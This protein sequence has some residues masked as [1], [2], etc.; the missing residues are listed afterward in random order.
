MPRSVTAC[1]AAAITRASCFQPKPGV[2]CR[3]GDAHDG[4][5]SE[6]GQGRPN[7]GLPYNRHVH[8]LVVT[9]GF[10]L[11]GEVA[12][13]GAKNAILKH[14][15]ATL[16]AP[17]ELS[18]R[19]RPR[20][21]RCHLDGQRDRAHWRHVPLLGYECGDRCSRRGLVP[22]AP[23]D[24][25]RRMRASILVLGAL[26]ARCGEAR[27]ALPGGDDFGSRPI[28]M[29]LDGLK[30][31]GA[32]F[33]LV[34]GELRSRYRRA[35]RRRGVST[36]LGRRHRKRPVRRSDGARNHRDQ[37]R[38]AR[39]RDSGSRRVPR[40]DGGRSSAEPAPRPS[41]SMVSPASRPRPTGRCRIGSKQA[42]ISWRVRSPEAT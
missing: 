4:Q 16:M 27:V 36:S 22:E 1:P 37:Q 38:G 31:M 21:R 42:R 26:L 25:V 8:Q 11:R 13:L 33:E 20:H 30:A 10:P 32:E 41:R 28:D 7:S 15:V 35:P 19:Q 3:D 29:H 40:K 12:V 34:H 39:T 24:L 23:I 9:G 14:L 6:Q 17:G 2:I 5:G 18:P